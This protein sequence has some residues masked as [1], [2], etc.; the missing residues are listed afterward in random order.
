MRRHSFQSE[1]SEDVPSDIAGIP[2]TNDVLAAHHEAITLR[3]R[4]D[5]SSQTLVLS[6]VRSFYFM[7]QVNADIVHAKVLPEGLKES[8]AVLR[9][10]LLRLAVIAIGTVNDTSARTSSLHNTVHAVRAKLAELNTPDASAALELV[11][12]VRSSIDANTQTPLR[13]VRHLR[14]KWA[15]HAS[16]DRDV[17]DWA[18]AHQTVSLVR[19]EKALEILVNAHQDLYEVLALSDSA[20]TLLAPS[21]P[22]VETSPQ[23]D[24]GVEW[25]NVVV[26]AELTRASAQRAATRLLDRILRDQ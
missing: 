20:A 2:L 9:Q 1:Y 3:E 13:Y 17:D 21:V 4:L 6:A 5:A 15:G 14:N 10:D 25:E 19:V 18:G 11:E 16:T 26:L 7:K 8:V 23:T 24:L 12:S 22:T